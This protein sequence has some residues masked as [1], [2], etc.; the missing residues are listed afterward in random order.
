MEQA[1]TIEATLQ[2]YGEALY[3][4]NPDKIRQAFHPTA[5]ITGYLEGQL[6]EF[7]VDQLAEMVEKQ[8]PSD[9][10][11]DLPRLFEILSTHQSGQ[12]AMAVVRDQFMGMT[13]LDTLSL[14]EVDGQWVIYN[15]LFHVEG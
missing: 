6:G 4:S 2:T 12:T 7:T 1:S 8:V 9:Q 15:K 14:L 11:K 10:E 3:Q 13:F 5:K